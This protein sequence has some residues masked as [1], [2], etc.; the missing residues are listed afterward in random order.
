MPKREK[1]SIGKPPV[2]SK[3]VSEEVYTDPFDLNEVN[4]ISIQYGDKHL[5]TEEM[6]LKPPMV[7]REQSQNESNTSKQM[8]FTLAGFTPPKNSEDDQEIERIERGYENGLRLQDD[9]LTEQVQLVKKIYN[10]FV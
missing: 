10:N 1:G 5:I 8:E 9:S 7:Q 6:E 2:M 3:R 4:A